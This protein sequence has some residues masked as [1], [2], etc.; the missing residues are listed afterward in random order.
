MKGEFL[1]LENY[2]KKK[3]RRCPADACDREGAV[4]TRAGM[5]MPGA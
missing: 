4:K 3:S 1:P 5:T 2:Q